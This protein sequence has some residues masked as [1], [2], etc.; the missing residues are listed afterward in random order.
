VAIGRS[1]EL[2]PSIYGRLGQKELV[3]QPATARTKKGSR[4]RF[5][6]GERDGGVKEKEVMSPGSLE[7]NRMGKGPDACF[8]AKQR[9]I[10][11]PAPEKHILPD[12]GLEVT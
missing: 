3:A 7:R 5:C 6:F 2:C 9:Y 4:G 10:R 1:L 11:R 8:A 12:V